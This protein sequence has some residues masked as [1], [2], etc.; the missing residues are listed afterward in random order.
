MTAMAE[1]ASAERPAEVAVPE[2]LLPSFPT[3]SLT[4]HLACYGPL[5]AI[6]GR[7][8]QFL[9]EIEAAGLTGR[10]GAGFPTARKL[11]TVASK[12][13]RVRPGRHCRVD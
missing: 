2:R 7:R 3:T 11:R 8:E 4:A 9:D 13:A 10:G 5:P 12:P 6:A 1:T